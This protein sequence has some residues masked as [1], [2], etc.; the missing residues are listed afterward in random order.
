MNKKKD[1][2]IITLGNRKEPEVNPLSKEWGNYVTLL[3]QLRK[4]KSFIPRGIYRFNTFEEANWWNDR[5][6]LGEKPTV[7]YRR[8]MI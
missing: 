4:D 8:R 1:Y 7:E 3:W 2:E 6:I 5:M